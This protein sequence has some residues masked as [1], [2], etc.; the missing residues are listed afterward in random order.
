MGGRKYFRSAHKSVKIMSH[1]A[2]SAL[3]LA[4][5]CVV[6]NGWSHAKLR[7]SYGITFPTLR[8]IRNGVKG[9]VCTDEYC[10]RVFLSILNEEYDRRL[11]NSGEGCGDLNRAFRAILMAEHEVRR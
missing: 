4:Y 1:K 8:R 3:T 9:K 11:N 7:D 2:K 5:D 6:R 10:M